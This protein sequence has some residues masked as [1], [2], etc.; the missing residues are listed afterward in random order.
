MARRTT[1]DEPALVD[2][3]EL[4]RQAQPRFTLAGRASADAHRRA[5]LTRGELLLRH[6]DRIDPSCQWL[7]KV[8]YATKEKPRFCGHQVIAVGF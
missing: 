8:D 3:R 5:L 6:A 4:R 7:T 2:P 1:P